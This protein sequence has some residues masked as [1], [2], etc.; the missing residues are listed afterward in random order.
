MTPIKPA[1][2]Q[3]FTSPSRDL[4]LPPLV[5]PIQALIKVPDTPF[6]HSLQMWVIFFVFLSFMVS[7][8]LTSS[9]SGYKFRHEWLLCWHFVTFH[10]FAVSFFSVYSVECVS[11]FKSFV[12]IVFYAYI[13]VF[14]KGFRPLTLV[15]IEFDVD[16]FFY[17]SNMIVAFITPSIVFS[18][19]PLWDFW[20][21]RIS[22]YL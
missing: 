19:L 4:I 21:W 2:L 13:Y 18:S 11:C 5:S 9:F 1:R 22:Q 7:F 8:F 15:L 16:L 3:N 20:L 6:S 10:E 17:N 12:V 14:I